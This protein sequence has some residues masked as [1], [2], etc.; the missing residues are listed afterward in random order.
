MLFGHNFVQVPHDISLSN[1]STDDTTLLHYSEE[2][3]LFS[4]NKLMATHRLF[5][6]ASSHKFHR[7]IFNMLFVQESKMQYYSLGDGLFQM[8][9]SWVFSKLAFLQK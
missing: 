9:S 8:I 7:Q 4:V 2:I 6:G 1:A 5:I 3:W